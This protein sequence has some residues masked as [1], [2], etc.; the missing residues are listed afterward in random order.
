MLRVCSFPVAITVVSALA[1]LAPAS[2]AHAGHGHAPTPKC[3][4][5]RATIVSPGPDGVFHGTGRRD[6]IVGTPGN[7]VIFAGGGDDLVCGGDGSDRLYG[8]AGDDRLYGG[9][10]ELRSIEEDTE[11]ER[12]GDLL[13]GGPGDDHMNAGSDLRPADLDDIVPDEISWDGSAHGMHIDLQRRTARGQGDDTFAGGTFTVVTSAHRDVV[14]GSDHGDIIFT[15]AGPDVV[16]ARGGDDTVDVG[17]YPHPGTSRARVW[18]GAGDDFLIG[19][20]RQVR[21]WGG[22]GKD[23]ISAAGRGSRLFGG[24]GGDDLGGANVMAGGPGDD[25][26]TGL[27]GEGAVFDGGPGRDWIQLDSTIE[28]HRF[29]PSTGTWDMSTGAVTFTIADTIRLS[30]SNLEGANLSGWGTAWTVTGTQGDDDVR[31]DGNT[32]SP[33]TFYGL[34]GDDTFSGSEGDD[35]FDGGP[36]NDHSYG[37]DLGDDTCISVETID[38]GD[39]EHVS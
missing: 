19:T 17:V 8:G 21:I 15:G 28:G 31:G 13:R 34:G 26:L 22:P 6:V 33:V 38:N 27:L 29:T 25:H 7:D 4:G 16:H 23:R 36:G 9:K 2:V 10:D 32:V 20:G 30:A 18:G 14:D 24:P 5:V 39:C 1:V 37:M 35:L 3:H 12:V 11:I